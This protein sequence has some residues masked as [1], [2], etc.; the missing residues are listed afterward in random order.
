MLPIALAFLPGLVTHWPPRQRLAEFRIPLGVIPDD[1][2][3][4]LGCVGDRQRALLLH[5]R[6]HVRD[7][8][9]LRDIVTDLVE[10]RLRRR[11]R[12]SMPNQDS[13]L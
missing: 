8:D 3:E 5:A 1:H 2:I 6:A 10:D 9:R 7:T 11:R 12:A 13:Y 4:L